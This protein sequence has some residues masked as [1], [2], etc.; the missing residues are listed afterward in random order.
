MATYID[1][2]KKKQAGVA[3]DAAVQQQPQQPLPAKASM[4]E[5]N[6]RLP[7]G[8]LNSPVNTLSVNNGQGGQGLAQFA[9]NRNLTGDQLSGLTSQLSYNASDQ[10]KA[11]FARD[12]AETQMRLDQAAASD[13]AKQQQ[14]EI[15]QLKNLALYGGGTGN[16]TLPEYRQANRRQDAARQLLGD[17]TQQQSARENANAGLANAQFNAQNDALAMQQKYGLEQ[18][19]LGLEQQKLDRN[20]YNTVVD[21]LTGETTLNVRSGK[22][23]D[24]AYK[25]QAIKPLFDKRGEDQNYLQLL[26]ELQAKGLS[27]TQL[28]SEADKVYRSYLMDYS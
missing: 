12:A 24:Q 16:M 15:G 28:N 25:E 18:Q 13:A 3:K 14:A 6:Y 23:A 27:G 8:K 17:A 21:P 19:K 4:V 26:K 5:N 2:F 7:G 11:N 9:D 20:Q 10:G 1:P 22:M